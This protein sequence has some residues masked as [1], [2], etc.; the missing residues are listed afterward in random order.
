VLGAFIAPIV[1][2]VSIDAIPDLIKVP[3]FILMLVMM[4]AYMIK[5][6]AVLMMLDMGLAAVHCRNT[7]RKQFKL[8]KL[9]KTSKIQR[10]LTHYGHGYTCTAIQPKPTALRYK[11]NTPIT[12]YSSGIEKIVVTYNVNFLDK[13]RYSDI[14]R[15]AIANSKSLSGKEKPLFL[16]KVQKKQ[17]RNRVTVIAII[18]Q[19][20]EESFWNSAFDEVCKQDGDG[21]DN[22]VVPCIIDVGRKMCIFN[23]ERYGYNGFAYPV[24]NRGVRIIRKAVFGGRLPLRNNPHTLEP[25]KDA[26]TNQTLWEFWRMLQKELVLADKENEKRFGKMNHGEIVFEDDYLYVKWEDKGVWLY[27]ELNEEEKTA[28]IDPIHSWDYPKANTIAKNTVSEIKQIIKEHFANLGYDC[29][30]LSL[31]D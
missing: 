30:F 6:F 1:V 31:D 27:V 4:L 5:N 12:V 8:R 3:F 7:S 10:K 24:K 16:D 22:S 20:T 13:N 15:S 18:V 11:L 25:I 14:F 23:C 2:V 28:S 17:S 9:R 21:F 26:D 29:K 19:N